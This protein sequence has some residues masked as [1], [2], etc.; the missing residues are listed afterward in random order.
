M[1]RLTLV[2]VLGHK[3]RYAMTAFAVLLGVA[4]IAGTL[5]LTDTIGRTFDGLFV[6]I[7]HNTAAVVRA[8]ESF[9]PQNDFSSER[10]RIPA[11][12]ADQIRQVPGVAA[13]RLGIDGYAQLIG[14]NGKAIG[15]PGAG[16]PTLGQAW[17]DVPA[18][19]PYHFLP[20]SQPP[21]AAGEVAIDKHSAD[22]GK[23]KVGDRVRVLTKGSPASYTIS[24]I[25]RWGT[26]DSPLGASITLFQ[27]ATA[28]AVLGEPGKVNQIDVAAT[29]GVSQSELANRLRSALHDPSLEVLTGKQ[30]TKEG[31]SGVRKALSFFNTFLLIFALIALFVGSFLIFNTFSIVVAQRLR[32]LG[33]LRA[34]GA[35]R[36][37]VTLSVLGESLV[38]GVIA[39]VAGLAAG[40]GLAIG[41]RQLLV[42]FGIDIPSSGLLVSFR[43]VLVSLVVGTVITLLAAFQPARR[44]GLVAPVVAMRD[45][46]ASEEPR[47]L[48]RSIS[49]GV[50]LAF[51][52][53][54]LLVGLFAEVSNRLALVGVGGT[55]TFLGIAI[56]GPLIS[57]P[58]SRLIGA[59]LLV[60]GPIGR[61]A[62]NNAMRMPKRTAATAAA[63]MIGV[64]LVA[65]MS[66]LADSTTS[67]VGSVIDR[68][69][70][71][72]F[73]INS[74]GQPGGPTGFSPA[75]RQQLDTLPA[76]ASST[77]IR[78][79]SV[80]IDG[81]G[82]VVL[83]VDPSRIDDLFDVGLAEG[84]LRGM[85]PTGV[86]ISRQVADS[87]HLR[88]GSTLPIQFTGGTK[89]FTVQAIYTARD[90]A[91]DYVLPLAAAEQNFTQQLDFQVYLRLAPGVSATAGRTAVDSVLASY[92]TAHL[93]DRT[94]Y[95]AAQTRQIDQL[96]NLVYGLLG[97]AL[98]IALVGIANT[99]ALSIH[100][101]TRELGLLRAVGMTRAQVRTTV[102]Y[103]S[104]IMALLGTLQGLLIGV[105][106]GW[107]IVT[108]MHSQGITVLSIPVLRL[109]IIA[110]LAAGA[111]V[112]AAVAPGRR[113]ARLNVLTAIATE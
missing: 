25:F 70:R 108:A 110:V 35:S 1:L 41:L 44:A 34:V 52:G 26:A 94:E 71:A 20:G 99:L 22:V 14:S 21:D 77:G 96:L 93:Q 46:A 82:M 53:S 76:V 2:G 36:K 63:L 59:P 98:F 19:N 9:T 69:M 81:S 45:N 42:A 112:L 50:V 38:I 32:E 97:L 30:I 65:V 92:P 113:A 86:A 111:G 78:A 100:E 89:P 61:L 29:S 80:R 88:L 72:D 85:T 47:R 16:A 27:P 64:A 33:L 87:K 105:L 18:M 49:G 84:S 66:V 62:R 17:N 12:V 6:D 73:V 40:I 91:G 107:A 8:Q 79:G 10:P 54:L 23:L 60:R 28:A 5:V 57:R 75:L 102:R 109:V 3:L 43:T 74:G 56:L 39:S 31:Q 7:Y 11:S 24:G 106:L 67:S 101:R 13:V 90:L 95:K 103:E 68:T 15:N 37:Q 104:L 51:G 4:F 48:R 58:L 83:A 55:I